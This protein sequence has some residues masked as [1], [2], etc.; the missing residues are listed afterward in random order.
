M[1][2]MGMRWAGNRISTGWKWVI[3]ALFFLVALP[4][5]LMG[6][7][8]DRNRTTPPASSITSESII[9]E[10]SDGNEFSAAAIENSTGAQ[11]AGSTIDTASAVAASS[12]DPLIGR[13]RDLMGDKTSPAVAA[14]ETQPQTRET[15]WTSAFMR[16]AG[17]LALVIGG[18]VVIVY[19]ARRVTYGGNALAS[20]HLKVVSKTWLSSRA[21]VY[22]VRVPGKILVV[23]ESPNGVTL[24]SELTDEAL[25]RE[26][27]T[28]E[29]ATGRT[30]SGGQ[31][32]Q[33]ALHKAE[34]ESQSADLA[35][36]V[37]DSIAYF[38]DLAQRK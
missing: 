11:E 19:I 28:P 16:L 34:A 25:A 32:F 1:N 13:I 21:S 14:R 30:V 3:G 8:G 26:L 12:S 33:K 9:T 31:A 10:S 15:S 36:K 29:E 35:L 20:S 17:G 7:S 4:L 37:R 24:L 18:I 23:G 22:L 27:E 5:F 2:I 38:R 6:G